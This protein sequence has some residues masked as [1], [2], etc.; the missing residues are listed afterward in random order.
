MRFPGTDP[1]KWHKVFSWLPCKTIDRQ[2]V[3]LETVWRISYFAHEIDPHTPHSL[4]NDWCY[5]VVQEGEDK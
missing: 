4:L 5:R 3:W 1:R 2:W